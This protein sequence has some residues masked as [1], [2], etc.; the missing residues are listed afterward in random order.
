MRNIRVWKT[1]TL[2]IYKTADAY[3]EALEE[4]GYGIAGGADEILEKVRCAKRKM[5]VNLTTLS[6]GRLGFKNGAYYEDVCTRGVEM[7]MKLCPAEVGPA[8]R[9][10]CGKQ[11]RGWLNIA[12]KAIKGRIFAIESADDGLWLNT[13]DAPHRSGPFKKKN[14]DPLYGWNAAGDVFI[15]IQPKVRMKK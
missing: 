3:S 14:F 11:H 1:I 9:L 10:V 13:N 15:F 12:M 6:V 7:G 8:L 4:A 2:G 5:S